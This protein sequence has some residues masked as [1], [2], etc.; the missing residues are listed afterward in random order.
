ML[1]N[2]VKKSLE[3][4][5]R[6]GARSIAFPTLGT[7]N[8]RFPWS[9]AADVLTEQALEFSKRNPLTPLRDIRVVVFE[10]DPKSIQAFQ[11]DIVRVQSQYGS[12]GTTGPSVTTANYGG[13]QGS[14]T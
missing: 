6:L 10:K 5:H 11:S 7:G 12:V 9:V 13:R 2:I 3:E 4:A 1:R 14:M 8:L